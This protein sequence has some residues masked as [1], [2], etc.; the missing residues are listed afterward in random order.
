MSSLLTFDNISRSIKITKQSFNGLSLVL[1][2]TL[3]FTKHKAEKTLSTLVVATA[4]VNTNLRTK[5]S[6]IT[7]IGGAV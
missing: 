1:F 5:S 3:F 7:G 2:L 6:S 4:K